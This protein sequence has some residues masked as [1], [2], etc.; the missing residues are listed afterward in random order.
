ML[1]PHAQA[2]EA[3][4]QVLLARQFGSTFDRTFYA[5]EASGGFYYLDR[6]AYDIG[7]CRG[8]DLE[9]DHG[10]EPVHLCGCPGVAGMIG[11]PRVPYAGDGGVI[12]EAVSEGGRT[13]LP[14]VQP[15]RQGA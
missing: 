14:V 3:G 15:E 5:A 8:L 1:A 4:R 13:A 2:Q 7:C 10:A 9:P 12:S 11:Q 6:V